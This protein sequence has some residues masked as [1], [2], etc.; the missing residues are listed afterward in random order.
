MTPGH[1]THAQT[2]QLID[3]HYRAGRISRQSA[4]L[5]LAS[6]QQQLAVAA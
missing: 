6:V 4:W 5:D 3:A 1:T 2:D